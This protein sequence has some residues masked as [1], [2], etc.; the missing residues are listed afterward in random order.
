MQ[1]PFFWKKWPADYRVIWYTLSAIFIFS[2]VFVW[3]NY[4][5][6][7]NAIIHWEKVQEQKTI[8]TTV[9]DFRLGPFQLSIPGESYVIFEY[10]A[11]SD[12]THNAVASYI[13]VTVF[14]IAVI[15][16]LSLVTTLER[17]WYF[18][19]MTVF[20]I[21]MVTLKLEVLALFGVNGLLIPI[22]I[23][24]MYVIVSFIF[25]Y[26]KP[27]T[28]FLVRFLTYLA[29][30]L[31]LVITIALFSK[32]EYPFIHLAV[33]V[34]PAAIILTVL[35]IITVA[36]EILVSFV[37]IAGQG[38]TSESAK[39][40]SIISFIYMI[41]VIITC[42]HEIGTLN[43]NF[44]YINLYLLLTI[45]AF[46][47][48]WGFR[49]REPQYERIFPYE[50][51]GAYF[52][53]ALGAI[54]FATIGQLLGNAN[55]AALKI[56]RDFIIFTHT[57]FGI[58][59][60]IYFFSN[61]LVMMASDIPVYRL[62]YKP[63]RMPY[64]TFRFAGL[65]AT[66]AFVF[67]SNWR[68]YIYHG[69]AGFYNY[70]ADLYILQD[71]EKLGIVFYDQSKSRAF[72]SNRANYALGKL[73]TSRMDLQRAQ[74]NYQLA[75]GKRPTE[76]SLVNE[77][78]IFF[79]TRQYFEAIDGFRKAKNKMPRS[80][81][82]DNNLGY[83]F[84]KVHVLDSAGYYLNEA[85]R[86]DLTKASAEANF[87]AMAASEYIPVNADSVLRLF[88]A[89]AKSVSANAIAL[90]TLFGQKIN[91]EQDPLSERVLDL[92]SATYLNN[93]I[94]RNAGELD[95]AWTNKAY[96]LATDS[97]NYDYS[98]ALRAS[99]AHA[100]YQQGNIQK[101]VQILTELAYITQNYQGKFNYIMGLWALEQ[102]A[103]SFAATY[104]R[105]AE[106]SDYKFGKFYR[107]IALTEARQI[108]EALMSWDSL[109]TNADEGVRTIAARLSNI[110]RLSPAQAFSLS[111]G[112]K[113]QFCRYKLGLGDT[114]IF[115]RLVNSFH[116]V[117]YKAQSLLDLSQRFYK[118]DRIVPA[119]RFFN[120]ISGLQLTDKTLFEKVRQF[121]LLMLASRG[122]LRNLARQIN[123]G[124]IQFAKEHQ[125][126]KLLYSTLLYEINGDLATAG[127]NYE[128][129]GVVNPFFEEGILAAA[130]FFRRQDQKSIKPYTILTDAMYVNGR[131]L[132]I[133][134]AYAAEAARQGFDE[135]AS[136]ATRTLME[137]E[138]EMR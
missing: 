2:V 30:T 138:R 87:F 15:L 93:Y 116:D 77:V 124:G 20:I 94:I 108:Q 125:L 49:L 137:I 82:I 63:N 16:L 84:A 36:H 27:R 92:Y 104:F 51:F 14:A 105:F 102:G 5:N 132:K 85:R 136:S 59:F 106:S 37:F 54:S 17:F 117:N 110:L 62:L 50:P 48:I 130:E 95:S 131:S 86:N 135:Y 128:V 24:A 133:L 67:Y 109:S 99:L 113:Y 22:V 11:G 31:A 69:A 74:Y 103:P 29:V 35:F 7:A 114:V 91:T 33:T 134:K 119:I 98:E 73:R 23:L 58:V 42:L 1:S 53:V 101:A 12:L 4:F 25:K 64:F 111:D 19:G 121:E 38:K 78:N 112:D 107:A 46:L 83:S 129:L 52:I 10:F 120:R 96:L 122:E 72:Q 89:E 100:Y 60:L 8:E 127:K 43:W 70:I 6:G 90:T 26:L 79:W 18:A 41:N 97:A 32:A 65:I 118:A 71:D 126:H 44:L 115:S 56:I 13:F 123:E 39:H 68:E 3:F 81:V 45:S 55:D 76:F 9:H 21:V 75:N 34:Y 40:F 57:G 47:S 66:L 28:P 80:P 88:D 61:F